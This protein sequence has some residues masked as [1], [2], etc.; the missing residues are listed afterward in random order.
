MF[1][2]L[3][4]EK[5]RQIPV[6]SSATGHLNPFTWG[7]LKELNLESWRKTPALE[8]MWYPSAVYCTN[9]WW[10]NIC[11]VLFHLI[12]ALLLDLYQLLSGQ[13]LKWVGYR[14]CF[15]SSYDK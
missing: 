6:Y 4:G 1:L 15:I 2:L 7:K 8:M 5:F 11:L 12:P 14:T 13:R 10:F 3:S 9:Y